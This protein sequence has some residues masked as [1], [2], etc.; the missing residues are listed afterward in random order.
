[1]KHESITRT[2]KQNR[3]PCNGNI[4]I[5]LFHE[6]S[7]GKNMTAEFYGFQGHFPSEMYVTHNNTD[8]GC[9]CCCPLTF[10]GGHELNK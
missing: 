2:L 8:C 7:V 10:K 1:M 6:V 4:M 5:H 9:L 3:R